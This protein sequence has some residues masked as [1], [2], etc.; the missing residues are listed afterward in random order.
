MKQLQEFSGS[1]IGVLLSGAVLLLAAGCATEPT[2]PVDP[3]T[4]K[5]VLLKGAARYTTG[6]NSWQPLKVGD[7]V[8]PGTLIQT[9]GSSRVDLLLGTGSG[10]SLV[11]MSEDALLGINKLSETQAGADW[12]TETQ[13]DLKAGRLH[14]T[15]RKMSAASVY[16]VQIPNGVA[17]IREAVYDIDVKGVVKVR[18][19]S[20]VLAY[21]D[22]NGA[23]VTQVIT[24]SPESDGHPVAPS[25][26][27]DPKRT[28]PVSRKF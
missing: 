12:V 17:G 26:F 23:V 21:A 20:V 4:A 7:V 5:V 18:S 19:G 3:G 6:D 28:P 14:G 9:A 10:Q 15:V 22:P 27:L 1:L 25:P 2:Q 11:Q 24:G 13:L 8:R 16:E